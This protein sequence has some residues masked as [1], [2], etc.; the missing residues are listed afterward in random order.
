MPPAR[1]DQDLLDLWRGGDLAAGEALFDRYYDLVYRFFS[2]EVDS[3]LASLV[4]ETFAACLEG[5]RMRM[6]PGRSVRVHLLAI[7]CR[8]LEA[9]LQASARSRGPISGEETT[10]AD[11]PAKAEPV[12]LLDSSTIE[13]PERDAAPGEPGDP[14]RLRRALRRLPLTERVLVALHDV[15]SLSEQDL[16]VVVGVPVHEVADRLSHA[17]ALLA[18]NLGASEPI[19]VADSSA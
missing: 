9:Q 11:L 14:Q 2:R 19:G 4:Q 1:S 3:D 13:M 6:R 17:R 16:A 8:V 7:A 12:E 18:G 10:E 15:E 5:R